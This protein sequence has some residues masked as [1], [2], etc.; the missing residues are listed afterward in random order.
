MLGYATTPNGAC[1]LC[2]PGAFNPLPNQTACRACPARSSHARLAS[3]VVSDC[4]CN[5]GSFW[6]FHEA[7]APNGAPGRCVACAA[8]QYKGGVGPA[9][10][11]TCMTDTWSNGT[12]ALACLPCQAQSAA[13]AGSDEHLDCACVTGFD[14][15]KTCQCLPPVALSL[16]RGKGIEPQVTVWDDAGIHTWLVAD[17]REDCSDACS[18]TGLRCTDKLH[19]N[20]FEAMSNTVM[21][22]VMDQIAAEMAENLN[23]KAVYWF[24][25]ARAPI[26]HVTQYG[27][28]C[29]PHDY[30][31][32]VQPFTC[33]GNEG[34]KRRLCPCVLTADPCWRGSSRTRRQRGSSPAGTRSRGWRAS[35]A[36]PSRIR[37]TASA[38]P[39]P[40]RSARPCTRGTRGRS[41]GR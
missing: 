11:A 30:L 21:P 39:R 24:Y 15:R 5:A 27:T 37:D 10:C 17:F 18:A 29:Y 2:A 14:Q 1:K 26:L 41:R 33:S 23:C 25:D 35:P 9:A 28:D 34:G 6:Q 4:V 22:V 36:A 20:V 38:W 31:D 13:P 8:G 7:T 16:F 32:D 19:Q 3:V 40:G 12:G